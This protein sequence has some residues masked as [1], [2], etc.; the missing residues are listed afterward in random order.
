MGTKPIKDILEINKDFIDKPKESE[1][2]LSETTMLCGGAG[3]NFASL[4]AQMV[5]C[6]T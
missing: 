4:G 1:F 3:V 2:Y 6:S 5:L